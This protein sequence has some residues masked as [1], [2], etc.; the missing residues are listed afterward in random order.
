MN[1]EILRKLI[2]CLLLT[3]NP[4]SVEFLSNIQADHEKVRMKVNIECELAMWREAEIFG[5]KRKNL[6]SGKSQSFF[7]LSVSQQASVYPF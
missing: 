3:R 6:R 4:V 7:V 1:L 2:L 5:L